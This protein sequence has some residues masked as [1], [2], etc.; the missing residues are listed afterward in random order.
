M[1]NPYT[2]TAGPAPA[3]AE[4]QRAADYQAAIGPNS[5]YYLPRFEEFDRAGAA[6]GW[7]WPA[8]F[9][10][11]PW[12]LYRKM[13]LPGILNVIYPF[14]LLIVCSIASVFL[15]RPIQAYPALFG[16]LFLALL[17]APW[18]LL[19]IY[20]NALYWQHIGKLV[21]RMPA[22]VAQVPQKRSARLESEGGT[23]VGAMIGICVGIGLFY[24][25][26][27][28]VLAAIA[29]PAYQ[30]YTIRAQVY[31]GLKL[32]APIEAEVAEFYAQRGTWPEQTDLGAEVPS[33]Q[34]VSQVVVKGGSVI[35][36]YGGKANTKLQQ[37][38]LALVPALNARGDIVWICGNRDVPPGTR[39]TA[40][41]PAG[42]DIP[43]KYL[44]SAC[45]KGS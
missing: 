28:G 1:E 23:G 2:H 13:W 6:P 25:F 14:V 18:F 27:V 7:H 35:I 38:G 9:V 3:T 17:A 19:P 45:R 39:R 24:V 4:D 32:A 8:F 42:S 12:F 31:E 10:T 44:P 5:D 21:G 36:V 40:D 30:D 26:V 34:Y 29:I 43:D 41:G 20:A 11:S 22:S 37:Q 15:S 16:L 33:G